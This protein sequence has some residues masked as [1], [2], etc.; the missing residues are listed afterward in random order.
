M[1]RRDEIADAVGEQPEHVSTIMTELMDFGAISRKREKV[2]GMRGPG[3]VRYFM[4]PKVATHLAG[5]ERDDA[6]AE[7]PLLRLMEADKAAAPKKAAAA[8]VVV[9]LR[10]AKAPAKAKAPP[11]E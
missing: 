5:K 2:G 9:S 4:N 10:R 1:L 6:Q 11:A 3:V 8:D 7:A